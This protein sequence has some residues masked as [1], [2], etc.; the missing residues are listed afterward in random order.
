MKNWLL[1]LN[2]ILLIAVASLF[3]LHFSSKKT[4]VPS[5]KYSEKNTTLSNNSFKFAYFD[6]DSVENNFY[7]VKDVK[8]ELNKKE[9]A[10]NIEV[11]NMQKEYNQ[12]VNEYQTKGSSMNQVQSEAATKDLMQMQEQMRNHK[13]NLDQEY[14]D[15]YMRRM[16]DVKTKIEEFLKEFNK[17]KKYSFILSSDPGL[18]YYKDTIYNITRDLVAGLNGLYKKK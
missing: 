10:I 13:Q 14:Q 3:Y 9:A 6:M 2:I 4:G 17:D 16:G 15:F 12:K 11:N 7:M 1:V 5:G 18:F 8:D